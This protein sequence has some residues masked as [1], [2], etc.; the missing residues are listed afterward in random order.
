M[1]TARPKEF[2][3]QSCEVDAVIWREKPFE[4][5]IL[6]E[7]SA[8]IPAKTFFFFFFGDHP[9]FGLKNRLNIR[10]W[11][12]FLGQNN[13]NSGQGCLQLSHSFKIAPG[14]FSNPG[15]ASGV[16]SAKTLFCILVD[17]AMGGGGL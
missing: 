13:E 1:K 8:S 15:Y 6:A 3:C 10:L 12:K 4:F 7:K 9:V 16:R 14:L 2:G 11:P 17:R 5:P